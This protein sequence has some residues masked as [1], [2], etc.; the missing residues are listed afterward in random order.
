M[1]EPSLNGQYLRRQVSTSPFKEID[2]HCA[3]VFNQ[4]T[5][6]RLTQGF[7]KQGSTY[8]K[9]VSGLPHRLLD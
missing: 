4:A 2:K 1:W 5:L 9:V 6:R 7:L 8:Y 3:H